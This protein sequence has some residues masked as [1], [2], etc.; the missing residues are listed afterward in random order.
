MTSNVGSASI[1]KGRMAIGFQTLN[2]TEE[3][4]YTVMKSLVM[5]ELKAF[6]RP[7]LLNRMDEVVVFRPLEKNQVCCFIL[8][9]F[10]IFL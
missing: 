4:T 6:F 2:D 1:S 8:S 7:E 10:V 5:E 3:N 9:S